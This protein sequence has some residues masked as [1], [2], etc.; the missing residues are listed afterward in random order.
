M[1]RTKIENEAIKR[2]REKEILE[3]A[4]RLFATKGISNTCIDDITRDL[5]ISHGLFYHY[6]K[7]KEELL[8]HIMSYVRTTIQSTLRLDLVE[9]NPVEAFVNI[10]EF[11]F[12]CLK[13]QKGT[14]ILSLY[15]DLFSD[16]KILS[17]VFKKSVGVDKPFSYLYN[18]LDQLSKQNK[19]VLN[20]PAEEYLMLLVTSLSGLCI[21]N[22]NCKGYLMTKH[23]PNIATFIG[24][25][26]KEEELKNVS[27][28]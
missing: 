8:H 6:F 14:F 13:T 21:A 26:I 9:S 27:I 24:F 19:L 4:L 11:F 22:I 7:N 18:V 2:K 17:T 12:S 3:S 1:P 10:I 25:F 5:E 15:F 16:I 20:K 28:I 23:K